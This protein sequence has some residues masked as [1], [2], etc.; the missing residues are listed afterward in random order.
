MNDIM[1]RINKI[2]KNENKDIHPTIPK[3]MLIECSNMCNLSCVFCANRKMT[4][5]KGKIS[6]EFLYKIL[7]EAYKL[8]TREVGFYMT[9]E[10]L[11]S[12]ELDKY[13]IAA[14]NIGYTYIYITTNGVLANVNKVKQLVKNGLNSLKFSINAINEKDYKMIHGYDKYNIVMHNLQKI[15]K[16]RNDNKANL[17][18][19]VSYI[20]TKYTEYSNEII[21]NH[22]KKYCDNV[23]ITNVRNQSGLV[24]EVEDFLKNKNENT[25]IQGD[26]TLP[27]YYPFNTLCITKEG[28]LTACCTDFQN[29]LAYADLNKTSLEKAWNSETIINLRKRHLNG[30]LK[31]TLCCNCIY[32]DRTLPTPLDTNLATKFD[33]DFLNDNK[34][35]INQIKKYKDTAK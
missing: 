10:P 27:C 25:K 14:H 21:I 32:D 28:Y 2:S 4:R 29:Y 17:K 7:K 26:R 15:W 23:L 5:K 3:N 1:K 22:F 18:I 20:S 34:Y 6:G 13:I 19:Y 35:V 24:P 12:T 8:G 9:G 30:N 16:W 11:L 31:G 33:N